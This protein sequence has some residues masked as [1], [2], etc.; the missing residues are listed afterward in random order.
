MERD[1]V[2]RPVPCHTCAQ[3]RGELAQMGQEAE[4]R[5]GR[6]AVTSAQSLSLVGEFHQPRD[7]LHDGQSAIV[8]AVTQLDFTSVQHHVL[9][10]VRP[11]MNNSI[12]S[13]MYLLFTAVNAASDLPELYLEKV[14]AHSSPLCAKL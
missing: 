4:D 3:T 1:V 9:V 6:R 5:Q 14:L 8:N 10:V 2:G 11:C 7:L 12:S 13:S